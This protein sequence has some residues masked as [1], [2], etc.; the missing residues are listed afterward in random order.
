MMTIPCWRAVTVVISL[1]VAVLVPSTGHLATAAGPWTCPQAQTLPMWTHAYGVY[2]G[3][4]PWPVELRVSWSCAV[5]HPLRNPISIDL[6]GPGRQYDG[7]IGATLDAR[8]RIVVDAMPTMD[9]KLRDEVH[10]LGTGSTT[11]RPCP[12]A[13]I[14]VQGVFS[15]DER[16]ANVTITVGRVRHSI[17]VTT[18]P[19]SAVVAR[20][21]RGV[22]AAINRRDWHTVCGYVFPDWR[23]T[24][25]EV[26]LTRLI[27]AEWPHVSLRGGSHLVSKHVAGFGTV[28]TY[29]AQITVDRHGQR[30]PAT[31]YFE[32]YGEHWWMFDSNAADVRGLQ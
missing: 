27:Q 17:H 28:Y 7:F 6:H 25:G 9:C 32:W 14:R 13:R 19:S 3:A 24:R 4:S 2:D 8:K 12:D 26:A 16:Q 5:A 29:D 31:I 15:A 23:Y 20:Y 18:T 1:V 22:V 11:G 10:G 21:A 30:R